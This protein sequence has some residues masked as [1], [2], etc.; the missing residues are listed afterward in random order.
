[1]RGKDSINA[2]WDDDGG[3]TVTLKLDL[4]FWLSLSDE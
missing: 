4:K 1:M 2:K 3:E